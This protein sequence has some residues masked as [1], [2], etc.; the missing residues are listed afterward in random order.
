MPRSRARLNLSS[1]TTQI[2]FVVAFFLFLEDDCFLVVSLALSSGL[3]LLFFLIFLE[4]RLQ[5]S[6][7]RRVNRRQAMSFFALARRSGI[8]RMQ[9]NFAHALHRTTSRSATRRQNGGIG[10]PTGFYQYQ[11]RVNE[12]AITLQPRSWFSSLPLPEDGPAETRY[13]RNCKTLTLKH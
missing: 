11:H 9:R 8:T 7:Y 5:S 12:S 2:P 6:I 3:F 13:F 10:F 1:P 4:S